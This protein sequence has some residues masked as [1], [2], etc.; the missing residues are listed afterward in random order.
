LTFGKVP[1]EMTLSIL[2]EPRGESEVLERIRALKKFELETSEQSLKF[3]LDQIE[4]LDEV[5]K[6]PR[7]MRF[8]M[9]SPLASPL[10]TKGDANSQDYIHYADPEFSES[11]KAIL[12]AKYERWKGKRI[13]DQRLI[14]RLD[15]RYVQRR[16]GRISKLVTFY[17]G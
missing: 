13:D 15:H 17:E 6:F 9:L 10:W 11:I 1:M 14:F 8:R 7:R 3:S 2:V 16:R 5:K 12:L 4:M